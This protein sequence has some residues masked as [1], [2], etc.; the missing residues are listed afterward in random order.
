MPSPR[1][2]LFWIDRR[3]FLETAGVL[4]GAVVI[5]P[6]HVGAA[7]M[8]AVPAQRANNPEYWMV[9][10]FVL[11]DVT[12]GESVFTPKRDRMPNYGRNYGGDK[13]I[14]GGT[15]GS[16]SVAVAPVRRATPATPPDRTRC[17][18]CH[19]PTIASARP[20]RSRQPSGRSART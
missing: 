6:H 18:S 19:P 8:L 9:R 11:S 15:M 7:E 13:E 10:P 3:D 5:D 12:L 14:L 1:H 4:T 17:V 20:A 2:H 16:I